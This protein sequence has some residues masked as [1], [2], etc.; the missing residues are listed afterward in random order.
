MQIIEELLQWKVA[1]PVQKT[2]INGPGDTLRWP[3]NTLESAQVGAKFSG[4]WLLPS[5]ISS[6]VD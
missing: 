2:E 6:L 4:K 1:A 3:R 5:R